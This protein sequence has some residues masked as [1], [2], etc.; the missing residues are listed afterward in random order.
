MAEFNDPDYLE[1]LRYEALQPRDL[2]LDGDKREALVDLMFQSVKS[3]YPDIDVSD[4]IVFAESTASLFLDMNSAVADGRLRA[5][6]KYSIPRLVA[7]FD[8]ETNLPIASL[9]AADNAS[10]SK[11]G[12]VNQLEIKAKLRLRPLAHKRW[13]WLGARAISPELLPDKGYSEAITV[14][15]VLGFISLQ[16][17]LSVQP[18]SAYPWS[19]EDWWQISLDSWGLTK[20]EG[21]DETIEPFG[22]SYRGQRALVQSRWSVSSKALLEERIA[23]KDNA[24][25]VLGRVMAQLA[26]T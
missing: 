11:P 19:G 25:P 1:E 12:P 16:D 15:D 9:I 13:H 10:S 3:D 6:Q 24:K 7:A 23:Q 20:D 5:N 2:R 21:S 18:V 8:P 4:A 14:V 17:K 26:K 22:N